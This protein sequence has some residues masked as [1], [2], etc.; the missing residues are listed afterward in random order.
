M[1]LSQSVISESAVWSL[2]HPPDRPMQPFGSV[3]VQNPVPE[4]PGVVI[5]HTLHHST[6]EKAEL[7]PRRAGQLKASRLR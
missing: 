2:G 4:S 7:P 1:H 5:H 6:S 3:H